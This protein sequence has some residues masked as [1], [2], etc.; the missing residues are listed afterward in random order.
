METFGDIEIN[1]FAFETG[2]QK[3]AQAG[4]RL[5]K[6]LKKTLNFCSPSQVQGL[7]VYVTVSHLLSVRDQ[8]KGL[9][10]ARQALYQLSCKSSPK[11]P[12]F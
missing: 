6:Y 9:A 4:F 3:I 10:D 7:Q 5:T 11:Y 1:V 12:E 8:T 2:S